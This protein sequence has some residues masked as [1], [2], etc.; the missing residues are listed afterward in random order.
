MVPGFTGYPVRRQRSV[1]QGTMT[2]IGTVEV[3]R[4]HADLW[5]VALV[6]EHDLS[7]AGVID[8]RLAV[9]HSHGTRVI[10][11]LSQASFVDTSVIAVIVRERE[12]AASSAEDD[13][14]VVAPTGSQPRRA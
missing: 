11:D 8:E 1:N 14:A 6:D 10:L 3:R 2:P 9:V 12:R 7:T 5:V 13:L 4:Y